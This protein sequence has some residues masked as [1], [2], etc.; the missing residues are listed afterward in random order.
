MQCRG[1]SGELSDVTGSGVGVP[2]WLSP[3]AGCAS[4]LDCLLAPWPQASFLPTPVSSPAKMEKVI[5]TTLSGLFV[6]GNNSL[7]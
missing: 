1:W 5:L 3:G 2:L 6:A 7:Y 4:L